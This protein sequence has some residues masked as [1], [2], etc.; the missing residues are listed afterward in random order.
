[1]D[2]GDKCPKCNSGRMRVRTSWQ[3]GDKQIQ[4]LQCNNDDCKHTDESKKSVPAERVFR[5]ATA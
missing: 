2:S 4:K 5:R 1:M 3:V